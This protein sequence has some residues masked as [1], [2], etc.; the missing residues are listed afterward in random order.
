MAP[1]INT[2]YVSAFLVFFLLF[3]GVCS[4][5]QDKYVGTGYQ[6][7]GEFVGYNSTLSFISVRFKVRSHPEHYKV[8]T[9]RVDDDTRVFREGDL[10][11]TNEIFPG[12]RVKISAGLNSEG[13]VVAHIIEVKE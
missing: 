10:I 4:A 3:S 8:E 12:D 7:E 2:V 13:R 6:V 1:A 11:E 9:F 5:G